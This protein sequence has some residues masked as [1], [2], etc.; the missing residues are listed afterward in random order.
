M[1]G[2]GMSGGEMYVK[3]IVTVTNAIKDEYGNGE[4]IDGELAYDL[5]LDQSFDEWLRSKG[6]S[7]NMPPEQA[8]LVGTC[9]FFVMSLGMDSELLGNVMETA[10]GGD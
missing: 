2:A 9:F 3:G 8:L 5:D 7:E 10:G 6:M 1:A 4:R